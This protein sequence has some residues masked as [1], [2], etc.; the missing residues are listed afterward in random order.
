VKVID[1][2]TIIWLEDDLYDKIK[3]VWNDKNHIEGEIVMFGKYYNIY[4][5]TDKNEMEHVKN[6]LKQKP[7]L[8]VDGNDLMLFC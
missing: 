6:A 5:S 1:H 4:I 7:C 8:H 3:L 2:N